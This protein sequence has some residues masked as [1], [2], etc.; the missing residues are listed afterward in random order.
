MKTTI[1][2][3]ILFLCLTLSGCFKKPENINQTTASDLEPTEAKESLENN[4]PEQETDIDVSEFN[5]P[6]WIPYTNQ[7]FKYQIEYPASWYFL[8]DACCPPP[9][10]LVV[11]NNYSDTKA[12]FSAKQ[13][14][15]DVYGLNILC[16]Y[17]GKLDDIEEV[18]SQKSEGIENE[19]KKI[20]NFD[21]II[22]TKDQT[23]GDS[24][25]QVK[26]YYIV[27]D[28]QGCRITYDTSCPKCQRIAESFKFNK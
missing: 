6:D 16:I 7:K 12:E 21:T 28:N 18:Q 9:P 24:T 20:N 1:T 2:F 14:E 27:D 5:P 22:F 4:P 26:T 23:L 17:E 25:I 19:T 13:F 8:K 11:F 3:L 15:P 10:A